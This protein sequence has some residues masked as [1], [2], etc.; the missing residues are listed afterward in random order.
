MWR[1]DQSRSRLR[2]PDRR[3][4]AT[5]GRSVRAHVDAAE[6]MA[7]I[8]PLPMGSASFSQSVAGS[9]YQRTCAPSSRVVPADAVR[10]MAVRQMA[11]ARRGRLR[12]DSTGRER[13]RRHSDTRMSGKIRLAWRFV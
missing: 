3:S 13:S 2:I 12:T 7:P 8:R 11:A 9:S 10:Q 4:T 6:I 5:L 1:A